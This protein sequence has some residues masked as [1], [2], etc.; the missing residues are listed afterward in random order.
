MKK[1]GKTNRFHPEAL[2][3][4]KENGSNGKEKNQIK[5]VNN[6]EIE[7]ELSDTEKKTCNSAINQSQSAIAGQRRSYG[8]IRLRFERIFNKFKIVKTKK[9]TN[10]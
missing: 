10:R 6:A 7:A 2:C 9:R 1:K 5:F 8:D 3:W 4:F